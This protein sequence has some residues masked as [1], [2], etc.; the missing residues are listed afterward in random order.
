LIEEGSLR[1]VAVAHVDRS[2]EEMLREMR[3]R[4]PFD[5]E[6]P[7]GVPKVLRTA[8][9]EIVTDIGDDWFQAAARDA[10][11]IEKMRALDFKSYLIV[12][13]IAQGRALGAISLV[14]A[15]SARRYSKDDLRLAE[16]LARRAALAIDNA[17]L[18]KE[19]Q[20]IARLKDEFLTTLSHELRTPLTSVLGWAR[21]LRVSDLD[22]ETFNHAIDSIERNAQAQT[23]LIQDIL[24]VSAI[25]TGKLKLKIGPVSLPHV[26]EDAIKSVQPAAEAKSIQVEVSCEGL[27][28]PIEADPDRLRQVIWNL[29]SNAIKFTPKDGRVEVR[30]TRNGSEAEITVS[31]TGYGIR[32]DFLPF[33][34]ERF[35]QADGSSTRAHGGLGLGLA[36][37][38]HLVEMHGGTVLAA[39]DGEGRG[40]SFTIR[41]PFTMP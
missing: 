3:R 4:Y 20:T 5:M 10:E 19:A 25:I 33:V 39:S 2:K 32:R 36:I 6:Q 37:V 21:L 41:L 24:D 27:L 8:Q 38:R 18:Y 34:F 30:A 26:I 9:P 16:D 14:S 29:L 17:R 1:Q 40:A 13:L 28:K 35:R 7:Y 15:Q 12:P 31:D 22:Q 23:Q 11:H